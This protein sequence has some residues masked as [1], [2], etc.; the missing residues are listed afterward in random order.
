MSGLHNPGKNENSRKNTVQGW[1]EWKNKQ[2]NPV[3]M[4]E[5]VGKLHSVQKKGRFQIKMLTR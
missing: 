4:S 3:G 5:A 1:Q 2:K